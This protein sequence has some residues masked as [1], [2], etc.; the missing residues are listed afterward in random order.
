MKI[1]NIFSYIVLFFAFLSVLLVCF[2]LFYPYKDFYFLTPKF[3]VA[4]KVVH[5]GGVVTYTSHYCKNFEH[6]IAVS[7]TFEN[8]LIFVTPA[9]INNRPK[10][11]HTIQV[12]VPVP[13]E[14]PVGVYHL[15]NVF[16][17]D[18]NPIRTITIVQN[19]EDFEVVE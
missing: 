15:S 10:G 7:R 4:N 13:E 2:W 3:T 16:R 6:V 5:Q 14:L 12:E 9:I 1:L 18:P 8:K 17:Y 19:T 11:C